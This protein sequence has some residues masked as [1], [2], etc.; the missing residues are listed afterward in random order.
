VAALSYGNRMVSLI[1]GV[2]SLALGTAIFPHFSRMVATGDWTGV[3][4]TVRAYGRLIILISLPT[5]LALVYFSD[6]IVTLLF[7]RGAFSSGAAQLV[8]RV[9]ALY[10]LQVPFYLLGIMGVR[11][12]SALKKNHVL[13]GIS[14]INLFINVI[15]NYVFMRYLGLAG[16]S[17]S[18]SVVYCVSAG[19]IYLFLR[20]CLRKENPYG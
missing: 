1:I 12:L 10:L 18:T 4:S 17:L 8:G 6:P 11:L 7:E 14:A 3:R 2:G 9:Q 15:A 5:T 16:I 13:M 19:L 20:P